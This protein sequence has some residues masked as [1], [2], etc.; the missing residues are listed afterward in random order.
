MV[1][2]LELRAGEQRGEDTMTEA[3]VGVVVEAEDGEQKNAGR[4]MQQLVGADGD[5]RVSDEQDLGQ[6]GAHRVPQRVRAVEGLRVM[7]QRMG[8]PEKGHPVLQALEPILQPVPEDG[9]DQSPGAPLPEAA[10]MESGKR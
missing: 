1:E 7:V 10:Q 9:I 5:K 8:A 4:E 6:T 2:P 3:D